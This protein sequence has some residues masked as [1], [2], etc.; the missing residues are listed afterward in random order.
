MYYVKVKDTEGKWVEVE[1]SKDI[2]DLFEQERKDL[3]NERKWN[4]RHLSD[5]DVDGTDTALKNKNKPTSLDDRVHHLTQLEQAKEVISS[6]SPIQRKRFYLNRIL[7]LTYEEIAQKEN[8]GKTA[9]FKSI[10]AVEKKLEKIK[11]L[12]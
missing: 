2:Y 8:C 5:Y 6:C 3:D 7:G 12:F 11:K 9:V 4:E 10:N 1:V